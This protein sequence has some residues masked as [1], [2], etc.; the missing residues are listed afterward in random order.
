M[1]LAL[2]ACNQSRFMLELTEHKQG[3]RE[4]EPEGLKYKRSGPIFCCGRQSGDDD[5]LFE[6]SPSSIMSCLNLVYGLI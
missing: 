3:K 4:T 6:L 5:K 2:C 1:A